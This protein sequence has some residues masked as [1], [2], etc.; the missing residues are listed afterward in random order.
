MT[1]RTATVARTSSGDRARDQASVEA[2]LPREY[3]VLAVWQQGTSTVALIS[4]RD[5]A[6]WTL[7]GYVLPRLASGGWYGREVDAGTARALHARS[8]L[9]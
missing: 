9:P 1:V 2:F 4:G 3:R 7:E 8:V 5:V 6:G